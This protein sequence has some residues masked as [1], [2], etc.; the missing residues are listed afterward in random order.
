M[1]DAVGDVSDMTEDECLLI[2]DSNSDPNDGYILIRIKGN[3]TQATWVK[4]N[5]NFEAAIG[6]GVSPNSD[7][8]HKIYEFAIP[9][10]YISAQPGDSIDFCSP[11]FKEAYSS[12][13]M[14]L[15][16]GTEPPYRDNIYPSELGMGDGWKY[17]ADGWGVMSLRSR[18]VGGYFAQVNK[19]NVLL[20]FLV[21]AGLCGFI[22]SI[23][24]LRRQRKI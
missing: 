17:S 2:F 8:P 11:Y 18:A 23:I 21:L 7:D 12:G 9:L 22:S 24:V 13:S 4:S 1:V 20:P 16:T 19:I 6:F 10:S 14:P 15:D 5:N 3:S